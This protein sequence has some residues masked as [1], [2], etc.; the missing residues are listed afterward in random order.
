[1][2]QSQQFNFDQTGTNYRKYVK[3]LLRVWY[4]FPLSVAIALGINYA[5]NKAARKQ[6]AVSCQIVFGNETTVNQDPNYYLGGY[7]FNQIN[8]INKE[9]GIIRSKRLAEQT[10]EQLNFKVSYYLLIRGK[11]IKRSRYGNI[12]F[13]ITSSQIED[14]PT[15]IEVYVKILN[16]YSAEITLENHKKESF[17]L[18]YGEEFHQYGFHFTFEKNEYQDIEEHLGNEYVFEFNNKAGL[19]NTFIRNLEIEEHP[20]SQ[21]ILTLT[22]KGESP[23][24]LVLYLNTLCNNYIENDREVRNRMANNTIKYIDS[25]LEILSNKVREAENNLILYRKKESIYS[26]DAGDQYF[27]E[28]VNIQSDIQ[29]I[30]IKIQGL[31]HVNLTVNSIVN[32]KKEIIPALLFENEGT[33]NE[34]IKKINEL[35]VTK[36]YLL[37]N[38]K[39]NSPE[40]MK[41]DQQIDIQM[42]LL[43]K[44]TDKNITSL[45]E[46][47]NRLEK[48]MQE[49]EKTMVDVPA[50]E[51]Q[52][53]KLERDFELA[54]DIFNL[55]QQKRI[56]AVLARAST[57]SNVRVLDPATFET[58][59]L[60]KPAKKKNRN[61]ALII[62]LFF[63]VLLLI[64]REQVSDVITD[65]K[66]VKRRLDLTIVGKLFHNRSKD[67]MVAENLPSSAITESFRSLLARLKF[68]ENGEKKQMINLTSGSSGDGKTFISL[69]LAILL[70]RGGKKTL[71]VSLDLRRPQLHHV[72]DKTNKTGLSTYLSGTHAYDEVVKKTH[73]DNLFFVPAGPV[74]PNPAELIQNKSLEK[75]FS[76]ARKKFDHILIDTPPVGIVAEAMIVNKFVDMNLFIIRI[77]H[78]RKTVFS[79]LE[80]FILNRSLKNLH[81]IVNDIREPE[82]YS[83]YAESKYG[84][85]YGQKSKRGIFDK[86]KFRK[87]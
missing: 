4:I 47:K 9:I 20:T 80:E 10:L 34:D 43:Q 84:E 2:E 74:P 55:Y 32:E 51:R 48:E 7:N 72:L 64:F 62:G 12:P 26:T 22:L 59:V 42:D 13:R 50:S 27:N 76:Q 16:P 54:Q 81:L 82:R 41:I 29:D 45:L 66:E 5:Y 11:W 52:L 69:N 65:E 18:K 36:Q 15:S 19:I 39:S 78:T 86:L 33:V 37:K 85:Y 68:A 35:I 23:E 40:V 24:Q 75:F 1:M 14:N 28:L 17:Y 8:P 77:G 58:L 53:S 6:Y 60:V 87:S 61:I 83:H 49:L 67:E 71:L 57:V 21:E 56:E 31:K 73:I 70:A 3:K 38:Q 44:V 79:L 30:D 63:P 25:Q 46:K